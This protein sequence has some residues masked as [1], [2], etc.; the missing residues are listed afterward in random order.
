MT[1]DE[2]ELPIKFLEEFEQKNQLDWETLIDS[3]LKGKPQE[4]L[5]E[6]ET[7]EGFT[8]KPI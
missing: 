8:L 5:Y 7:S 2:Y 3:S 4:G 1:K 6:R